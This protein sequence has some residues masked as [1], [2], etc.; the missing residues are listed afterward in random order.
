MENGLNTGITIFDKMVGEI[1]PGQLIVIAGRPCMGKTT[2]LLQILAKNCLNK[3]CA[4]LSSID[5]AADCMNNCT[6]I[7]GDLN[8]NEHET[9]V[10]DSVSEAIGGK[11]NKTLHL[12]TLDADFVFL[13]I[14]LTKI[15]ENKGLDYIFID[16]FQEFAT[17]ISAEL[18]VRWLKDL[19]QFLGVTIFITAKT[20][21]SRDYDRIDCTTINYDLYT[22]ADKVLG[23]YRKDFFMTISDIGR[24]KKGESFLS[25]MK[26]T[27]GEQGAVTAYFNYARCSFRETFLPENV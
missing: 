13:C 27:L 24:I 15:K 23:L 8:R 4:Y 16:G 21:L 19:A 26:N 17:D 3:K 22:T 10:W 11:L 7:L 6:Y 12:L 2:L 9:E 20:K 25:V 1:Y 18:R 14:E 5:N